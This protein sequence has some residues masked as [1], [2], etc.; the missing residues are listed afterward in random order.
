M[1]V[2]QS[3]IAALAE[4][5]VNV[6]LTTGYHALPKQVLPLPSNFHHA[7]YMPG[8]AMAERS[9]LLIHH[10]GYGSCQTGL[11]I[12]KPAVIIPTFSERES[13]ARRVAAT[14]AGTFVPVENG[15]GGKR[16]HVE[17][18]R[19][20]IKHGL[21]DPAFANNA[22]LISQRMRMYG[23]PSQAARLIEQFSQ[24]EGHSTSITHAITL[25]G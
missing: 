2:L 23:G 24:K 4:E 6:I 18:L 17:E 5:N 14:G 16:V 7:P 11:Y 20:T 25:Q 9:D 22:R 12:G 21:S 19:A 1:V 10:G 8:L 3:C 13:N 15:A